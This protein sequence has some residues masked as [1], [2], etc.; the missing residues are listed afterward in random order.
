MDLPANP[1]R[2]ADARPFGDPEPTEGEKNYVWTPVIPGTPRADVPDLAVKRWYSAHGNTVY[3][4]QRR[5]VTAANVVHL[6]D[7]TDLVIPAARHFSPGMTR[8]MRVL[9]AGGLMDK[10]GM[11][12]DIDKDQGFIDQFDTY[13][14]R[15]DAY[16]IAN[17]YGRI[18]HER[19][20]D[21]EELYSEGLH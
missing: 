15:R 2:T 10:R 4:V 18:I 1:A 16:I 3:E 14:S 12:G 19:N 17:L 5:I 6:L 9:E 11:R 13:H 8:I 7:G 21:D 20:G